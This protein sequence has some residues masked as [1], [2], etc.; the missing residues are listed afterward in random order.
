MKKEATTTKPRAKASCYLMMRSGPT[1][2]R[3]WHRDAA[4]EGNLPKSIW[5]RGRVHLATTTVG[6]EPSWSPS[7]IQQPPMKLTITVAATQFEAEEIHYHYRAARALPGDALDGGRRRG[8]YGRAEDPRLSSPARRPPHGGRDA[9][10]YSSRC[11]ASDDRG[12]F[13]CLVQME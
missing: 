9:F 10:K 2:S 7:S 12:A 1:V 13:M 5:D 4:A 3:R 6:L 8:L 11:K